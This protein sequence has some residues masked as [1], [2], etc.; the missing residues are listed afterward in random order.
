MDA[1][2]AAVAPPPGRRESF[3]TAATPVGDGG[4]TSDDDV[5]G[6]MTK[7]DTCYSFLVPEPSTPQA[8]H[9]NGQFSTRFR[10]DEV[11]DLIYLVTS[12]LFRCGTGVNAYFIVRPSLQGRIAEIAP[13]V[14]SRSVP[15]RTIRSE[16]YRS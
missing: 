13:S 7:T 6:H 12:S 11:M 16:R 8:Q 14:R 10:P 4:M 2:T 5:D 3:D 9:F 1:V 15:L